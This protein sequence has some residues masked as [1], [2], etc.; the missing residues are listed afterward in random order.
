MDATCGCQRPRLPATTVA[1]DTV[2]SDTVASDTVASDTVQT[3]G[4]LG[5]SRPDLLEA[6]GS[7]QKGAAEGAWGEAD[8]RD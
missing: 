2:A 6:E 5:E 8:W 3:T 7:N 4:W 1:S